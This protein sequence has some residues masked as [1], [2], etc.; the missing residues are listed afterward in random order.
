MKKRWSILN[1][2]DYCYF[3]GIPSKCTHEVFFGRNRQVSIQHGFC[4][5]LC[6]YHHNFSKQESVHFNHEMDLE[7]KQLYQKEFEKNHTRAEFIELIDKS[8]L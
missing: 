6:N 3:C 4:V 2:L 7:L 1:N 5:G 8:Y